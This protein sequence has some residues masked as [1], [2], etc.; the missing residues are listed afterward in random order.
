MNWDNDIKLEKAQQ[1]GIERSLFPDLTDDEKAIVNAL[2]KQNDLQ[3]NMLSV[4]SN[5]PIARLMALLF[6]LE[7]KGIVKTMAGG[8]YHLLDC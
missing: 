7:M 6:E 2:Q 5:L 8:C 4:Q 1:R 3:I